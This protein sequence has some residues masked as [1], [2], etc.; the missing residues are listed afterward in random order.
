M[1]GAFVRIWCFRTL[2][3]HFTFEVAIKRDHKLIS[4]GPYAHV[5]HPGYT[6]VALMMVGEAIL[7]CSPNS[8]INECKIMSTAAGRPLIPWAVFQLYVVGSLM[9]R[10]KIEDANLRA[11][12]GKTWDEY[13]R[14]V[15][16][17]FIP[18]IF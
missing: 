3:A 1:L 6:G 13:S 15:P 8:Y 17:R 2:G 11:T 4:S 14:A 9:R 7:A 18:Y 12:F 10:S 5:R 16:K